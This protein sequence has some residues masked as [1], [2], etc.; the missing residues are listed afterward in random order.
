M[1]GWVD[2]WAGSGYQ[3]L[4]IGFQVLSDTWH[5]AP[6]TFHPSPPTRPPLL[7]PR[8]QLVNQRRNPGR[9]PGGFK[10]RRDDGSPH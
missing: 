10:I 9:F 7:L 3:V 6:D 1:G 8:L 4:G 2:E 5:L